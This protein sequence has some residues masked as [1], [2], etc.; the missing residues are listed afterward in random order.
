MRSESHITLKPPRARQ[1]AQ[2][3]PPQVKKEY[4]NKRRVAYHQA[5][6]VLQ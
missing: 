5:D 4:K 6:D 2:S 1:Y 3:I